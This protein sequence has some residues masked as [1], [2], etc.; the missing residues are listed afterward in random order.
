MSQRFV[1]IICFGILFT[2]SPA[3]SADDFT[4]DAAHAGVNFKISHMGLSAIVGR[5]NE[6]SGDFSIDP[7]D[8]SKCS[9][10]LT[11]N[12]ETI[13]T[14][15]QKRDAHLRSPDFFN[16]KQFPT[17]TFKS[18]KVEAGKDGYQVTGDLTLHGVTKPITFALAGGR[19]TEFPKGVTRTG[20]TTELT[21][22]RSE[23]GIDKFS[24][25]LGEDVTAL[26][27]FEGTKK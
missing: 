4:V 24:P 18:T 17:I 5:F 20:F 3:R 1:S 27:S 6:F 2:A 15:N 10:T 13:D 11:I 7:D 14:N 21:L 16:T 9:F 23:F 12:A 25:M 26:I 22:K 8:A 19:K